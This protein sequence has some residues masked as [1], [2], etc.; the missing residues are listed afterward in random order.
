MPLCCLAGRRGLPGA[1]PCRPGTWDRPP[2]PGPGRCGPGKGSMVGACGSPPKGLPPASLPSTGNSHRFP[3]T[4]ATL[5]FPG[6]LQ[7]WCF[8]DCSQMELRGTGETRPGG[9]SRDGSGAAVCFP[10]WSTAPRFPQSKRSGLRLFPELSAWP[11]SKIWERRHTG[12]INSVFPSHSSY[13]YQHLHAPGPGASQSNSR[14]HHILLIN[15][16]VCRSQR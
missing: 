5:G 11:F 7:V 3:R 1:L 8:T 16:L 2:E 9:C 14:W 4:W 6:R 12:V 15:R 13:N 10:T